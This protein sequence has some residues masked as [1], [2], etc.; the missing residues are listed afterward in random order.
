M[1][2]YFQAPPPTPEHIM[3]ET[4]KWVAAVYVAK[5]TVTVDHPNGDTETIIIDRLPQRRR[6]DFCTD[7]ANCKRCM[8]PGWD[9]HKYAH[10]GI[11][12][13]ENQ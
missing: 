4:A 12:L 9:K 1:M 5:I 6:F 8:A 10:A 3:A 2:A 7:P 11:P 13:E